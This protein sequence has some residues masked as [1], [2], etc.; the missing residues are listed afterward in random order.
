[1]L[2]QLCPPLVGD[3]GKSFGALVSLSVKGR[4]ERTS[5]IGSRLEAETQVGRAELCFT[6][7]P[8]LHFGLMSLETSVLC[9][10]LQ[11][12]LMSLPGVRVSGD[13][14]PLLAP[15]CS[16]GLGGVPATGFQLVTGVCGFSFPSVSLT[17]TWSLWG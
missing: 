14:Q 7:S 16:A 3:L 10:L 4:G 17:V 1:M 6:R 15:G 5:Q 13:G 9:Q 11:V 8:A 2:P 12:T